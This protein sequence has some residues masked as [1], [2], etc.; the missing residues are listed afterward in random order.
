MIVEVR[1]QLMTHK[2]FSTG[3]FLDGHPSSYQP[4]PTGLDFLVTYSPR[5][6]SSA[7]QKKKKKK[8]FANCEKLFREYKVIPFKHFSITANS[9]LLCLLP[10]IICWNLLH[11]LDF[12]P[13]GYLGPYLEVTSSFPFEDIELYLS[14][15]SSVM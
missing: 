4:C 8:F 11:P 12:C 15:V 5:S 3:L 7:L 2:D 14:S 6:Q 9:L 1:V 13:N 10:L